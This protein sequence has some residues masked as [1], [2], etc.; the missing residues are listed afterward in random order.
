MKIGLDTVV[1]AVSFASSSP[2]SPPSHLSPST[3]S[4]PLFSLITFISSIPT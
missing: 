3:I 1:A 2:L 4:P